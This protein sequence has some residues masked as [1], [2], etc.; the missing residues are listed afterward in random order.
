MDSSNFYTARLEFTTANVLIL[1]LRR[2]VGAVE[3]Q[4]ATFTL[5]DTYTPGSTWVRVRFQVQGATL[6]ARAWLATGAE[7]A[8]SWQVTAT[9]SSH[10]TSAFLGTRSISSSANTNVNPVIS[11][12]NLRVINPQTLTVTRSVNGVTKAHTANADLSLAY[13]TYIAL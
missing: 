5:P 13:P 3:T 10:S 11:Y 12:D 1:S 4:L 2:F 6:R 9:D 7:P 8:G